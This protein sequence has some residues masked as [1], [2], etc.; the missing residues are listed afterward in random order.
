[1]EPETLEIDHR[2]KSRERSNCVFN[3]NTPRVPSDLEQIKCYTGG[4]LTFTLKKGRKEK[5]TRNKRVWRGTA[6]RLD[7]LCYCCYNTVKS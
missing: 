7:V 4:T 3:R 5:K 6:S 1:M 2:L